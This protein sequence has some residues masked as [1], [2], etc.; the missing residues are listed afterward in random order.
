MNKKYER[1]INYIVNDLKP[2]YFINMKDSYGLS[3]KE[4]ELV[5]SKLYNQPVT[6]EGRYVYDEYS[7]QIYY[8]ERNGSWSKQ[9]F[10][11]RGK[12]TYYETSDGY[13]YKKEYNEHG[14]IIYYE[15]SDGVW[16]KYE[17]DADGNEIYFENSDG[18]WEKKEYNEHGNRIYFEDSYGNITDRR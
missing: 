16:E 13:W 7:N 8:E 10:N 4:Y 2:P 5:L 9:E 17:Y 14:E 12:P 18:F 1:Y 3:E 6:I 11:E 15:N